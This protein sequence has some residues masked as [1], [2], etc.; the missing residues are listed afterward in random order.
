[1]VLNYDI[2]IIGGGPAGL[3]AAVSAYDN[4]CKNILI[5]ERDA[6]LGGILNQCI[7]NGFGL[8]RFKESL[9]GPEYAARFIQEVEKRGIKAL[10]QTTVL[11]LEEDK[12]LTLMNSQDGIF[13]IK[14]KSVVLAMGCRER[15]RGALN[16]PGSRPAGIFSAGTAQVYLNLKGY[17]PGKRVVI[18]GSGD[19]G[20]IMAR[21][22]TLEGAKV[23][24]VCEIMPYSSG[25]KRNIKQCLEDFDIPLYLNHTITA[26]EGKDRVSGVVVSKVDENKRP[27]PGT[28]M[29]FDCDTVLFSVGLIPENELSKGAN[30]QLSPKTRGAVVYQ[31]RETSVN[32]VFACGNVLQVHDLVD[33]VSEEGE[34]AGKSACEYLQKGEMPKDTISVINGKNIN[35]VVP[36]LID[37]NA[38][39]NVKLYFRVSNTFKDCTIKVTCGDKEI[40]SKKKMVAVP[41][42]METIVLTKDKI[43]SLDQDLTVWLEEGGK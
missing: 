12:T 22:M 43:S 39:G 20:L 32:G 31:N 14:A 40:L 27:I 41:G 25:L 33:F 5:V 11:S 28:E 4:G 7:H 3:A 15:S 42:E 18:L 35:Y 23:L 9:T 19:I 6:R 36:Q 37:K 38:D 30:I 2:V 24:A 8:Q 17:L 26:I 10:T 1:M 13:T 21:R 16:I 29:H 34:L